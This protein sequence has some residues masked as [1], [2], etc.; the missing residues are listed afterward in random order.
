MEPTLLI[1]TLSPNQWI[2]IDVLI[3]YSYRN[4]NIMFKPS[5]YLQKILRFLGC[6]YTYSYAL[7]I[8]K[9]VKNHF[10]NTQFQV[11]QQKTKFQKIAKYIKYMLNIFSDVVKSNFAVP[12]GQPPS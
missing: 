9:H 5:L 12:P 1:K 4:Y 11:I 10:I 7:T 6:K 3:S 2:K 8:Q